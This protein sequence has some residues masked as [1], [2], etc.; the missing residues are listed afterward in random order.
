MTPLKLDRPSEAVRSDM[1]A[2]VRHRLHGD[3]QVTLPDDL[4]P[5]KCETLEEAQRIAYP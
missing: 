4:R 3:W 2:V 5:V 1:P